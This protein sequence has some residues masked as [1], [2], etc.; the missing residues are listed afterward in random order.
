MLDCIDYYCIRPVLIPLLRRHSPYVNHCVCD[1]IDIIVYLWTSDKPPRAGPVNLAPV[2]RADDVPLVGTDGD[3]FSPLHLP[4]QGRCPLIH[5]RWSLMMIWWTHQCRCGLGCLKMFRMRE[6]CLACRQLRR[7]FWCDRRVP[8]Y[9]NQ[10]LVLPLPQVL[11]T[12]SDP[13][14]GNPIAVAQCILVSGSDT[15]LTS[16]VYMMPS[17]LAYIPG[18]SSVQTL[19]RRQHPLGRRGGPPV[20]PGLLR[21]LGKDHLMPM[22]PRWIR[23]IVLW[24]RRDC[25]AVRI[26]YYLLHRTS[27]R[28]FESGF[29]IAAP[30][31]PVYR[32]AGVCWSVVSF[33]T[34]WVE[35]LGEKDAMVAAVNL[36]WD[37]GLM[38]SNLQ[39]LLQFVMSLHRMSSE[40][41]TLGLGHV[42]F[43][44]QEVA[45]LYT[46]P[47]APREAKYVAAMGL[48]R[49]KTG[50]DD[51]GPVPALSCNACMNCRYCFPEGR[52]PPE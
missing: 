31:P 23:R 16:P 20:C 49:P 41:M 37:A 5:L 36:Q 26:S 1:W 3:P 32:G 52:L 43:P 7:D 33:P 29:W 34:C 22:L 10:W 18:Q 45:D 38:S 27:S 35:R 42:V 11:D 12:F 15:P 24:S 46:A 19:W 48:W 2:V 21:F 39:I 30:S 51:P 44:L 4:I 6:V 25:Q 40:M 28:R 47:R 17:G 8:L 50:P 14:L 13:V 9:S